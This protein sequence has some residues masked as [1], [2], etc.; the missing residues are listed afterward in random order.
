MTEPTAPTDPATAEQAAL[1]DAL[2]GL[3]AQV[4]RLAEIGRAHV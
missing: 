3:V 2:A 4:A 1:H